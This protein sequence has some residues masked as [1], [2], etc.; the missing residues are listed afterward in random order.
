MGDLRLLYNGI[1]SPPFC[2]RHTPGSGNN[3]LRQLSPQELTLV[4]I[5]RAKGILKK[6]Q[7]AIVT[8]G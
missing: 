4:I 5:P 8:A 2:L 7:S 1:S 6:T 3:S